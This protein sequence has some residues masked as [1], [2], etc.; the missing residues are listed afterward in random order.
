MCLTITYNIIPMH[1]IWG[2]KEKLMTNKCFFF[3]YLFVWLVGCF[4]VN[5]IND[6]HA[7]ANDLD[8]LWPM[9]NKC[10]QRT[11]NNKIK[12]FQCLEKCVTFPKQM[13]CSW[14]NFQEMI[15]QSYQN[16][17]IC[18]SSLINNFSLLP[19]GI[20]QSSLVKATEKLGE[21]G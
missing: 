17:Y 6:I 20:L 11:K 2:Q 15:W 18:R 19:L 8:F 4:T 10:L 14:T 3:H 16:T 12:P 9:R 7:F 13:I 21:K 5:L 1:S